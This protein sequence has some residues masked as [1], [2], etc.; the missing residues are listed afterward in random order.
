VSVRKGDSGS[1][2]D[3]VIR[4]AADAPRKRR[5]VLPLAGSCPLTTRQHVS[6]AQSAP[7]PPPWGRNAPGVECVGNGARVIAP[8]LRISLMRRNR[9]RTSL[10]GLS[11]KP[12]QETA[13]SS[14][15]ERRPRE[16]ADEGADSVA[17]G[18]PSRLR[19]QPRRLYPAYPIKRRRARREH[20]HPKASKT[21][22][23]IRLPPPFLK[24]ENGKD[25]AVSKRKYRFT[26]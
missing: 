1:L 12:R 11:G 2:V 17:R 25:G 7:A 20:R 4:P 24:E 26:G 23:G 18:Q 13:S 14:R 19:F 16:G 21:E 9:V 6:H 8:D 15:K 22:K 10:G 3:D 5:L